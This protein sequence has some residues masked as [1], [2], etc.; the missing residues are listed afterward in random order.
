MQQYKEEQN[1]KVGN[2]VAGLL[3]AV[4]LLSGSILVTNYLVDPLWHFEG[5]KVTNVNYAFNERVGRLNQLND[6]LHDYDC[7]IFGSSVSTVM[8]PRKIEGYNCFNFSFSAGDV[9]EFVVIA[10]YLQDRGFSPKAVFVE[11]NFSFGVP[12]SDPSQLPEYVKTGDTPT[13]PV[14]DYLSLESFFFSV[15]TLM[16]LPPLFQAYDENFVGYV[17]PKARNHKPSP[18]IVTRKTKPLKEDNLNKF[19]EI[20]AI[21]PAAKTIGYMHPMHAYHIARYFYAGV[22]EQFL[23]LMVKTS[24]IF[25]EVYD[26]S[27]PSEL[28]TNSSNTYDGAHFFEDTYVEV[29]R[30]ISGQESG[31]GLLVSD[32]PAYK[33]QYRLA[34][35]KFINEMENTEKQQDVY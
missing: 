20:R 17:L 2:F 27:V 14:R 26:F 22:Q 29:A 35:K 3:A 11:I 9:S 7:I 28:T 1:F 34:T 4:L 15:R 8:D 6:N 16:E 32:H 31:F 10:N 24:H 12:G 13:N 25:D 30:R 5:N 19:K 18:Q 21:F 33:S 23:N